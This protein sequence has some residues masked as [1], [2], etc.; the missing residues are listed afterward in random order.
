MT[1]IFLCTDILYFFK[2]SII[3]A[4]LGF[5]SSM[6]SNFDIPLL[7]AII[8][9]LQIQSRFHVSLL[10]FD[11]GRHTQCFVPRCSY[12]LIFGYLHTENHI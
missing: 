4:C 3:L 12:D 6:N 8:N 5:V 1:R 9:G 7:E 10:I 2:R 11:I